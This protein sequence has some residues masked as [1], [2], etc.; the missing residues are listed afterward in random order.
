[1]GVGPPAEVV[2]VGDVMPDKKPGPRPVVSN[3]DVLLMGDRGFARLL[4]SSNRKN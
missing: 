4:P 2:G 1:M 3:D